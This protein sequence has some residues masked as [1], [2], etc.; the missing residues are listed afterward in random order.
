MKNILLISVYLLL[1]GIISSI[2]YSY[3][4]NMFVEYSTSTSCSHCPCM[5]SLVEHIIMVQ[6]P[7]TNAVA[8]H[9][10]EGL[11]PFADF[12]G[13]G[14]VG[15]LSFYGMPMANIDRSLSFPCDYD[16]VVAKASLR[17]NSYPTTPVGLTI[18]SQGFN[19]NSRILT[20]TV[21]SVTNQTLNGVYCLT[22]IIYENNLMY[23]QLVGEC[24]GGPEYI[25]NLVAREISNNSYYGDTIVNGAWNANTSITKTYSTYI[26]PGWAAE[27]CKF[28]FALYKFLFFLF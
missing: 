16:T 23:Q 2:A 9:K 1:A 6:F 20:I 18:V 4:R 8:Y 22:M 27:N 17:F 26:K 3:P 24:G 15:A 7:G 19:P 21:K 5:D 13:K 11:D 25:H 28:V 12:R 10:Y 14:I